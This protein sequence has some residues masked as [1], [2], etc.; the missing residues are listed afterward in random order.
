V[1]RKSGDEDDDVDD[2]DESC[3]LTN[4][5]LSDESDTIWMDEGKHIVKS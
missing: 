3:C 4:L 1:T 2:V 5:M